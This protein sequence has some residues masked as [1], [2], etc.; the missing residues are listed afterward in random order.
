L[1]VFWSFL[2]NRRMNTDHGQ[3]LMDFL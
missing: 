1:I 3:A 2:E